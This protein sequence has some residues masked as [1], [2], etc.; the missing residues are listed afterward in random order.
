MQTPKEPRKRKKTDR[1]I[2]SELQKAPPRRRIDP[3]TAIETLEVLPAVSPPRKRAKDTTL[4]EG[5]HDGEEDLSPIIPGSS[6]EPTPA[7]SS[8]PSPL[9]LRVMHKD[10]PPPPLPVSQ[11]TVET[12]VVPRSPSLFET[13]QPLDPTGSPASTQQKP[14]VRWTEIM[15]EILLQTLE[16]IVKRGKT[17][18]G[19]KK[20]HWREVA[21]KVHDVYQGPA[22]LDWERVKSKFEDK[23]R[24]L[25]RK[26][27]D[28]SAGLSGWTENED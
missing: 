3:G 1:A 24:S 25:W 14:R 6:P 13:L 8:I 15:E 22:Q 10:M 23:Y 27:Q 17:S 19:F 9:S 20:E 12:P 21:V 26:W 16:E 4:D 28:H 18:D 5:F 2:E 7:A 11:I